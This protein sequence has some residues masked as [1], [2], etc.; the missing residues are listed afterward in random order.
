VPEAV[1][2]ECVADAGEFAAVIATLSLEAQQELFT[3]TF[4]LNPVCSLELGWHLFGENYER[5]LLLVR[6]REHLRLAAISENGE[7]PDHLTY[8]LRLLPRMEQEQAA[9]FAGAI[10]MPALAKMSH[11]IRDK[12]NPYEKLLHCLAVLMRSDLPEIPLPDNKVELPVLPREEVI[13]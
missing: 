2:A 13:L 1:P 12:K 9:D 8:A 7:L 4:D 6:M 10:V 5:G 3:Q 11:A